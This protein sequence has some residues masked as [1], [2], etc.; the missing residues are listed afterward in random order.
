MNNTE[1]IFDN[2]I[3][4]PLE[5]LGQSESSAEDMQQTEGGAPEEVNNEG[6]TSQPQEPEIDYKT[7]YERIKKSYDHLRPKFTKVT[8]ELSALRKQAIMPDNMQQ[9]IPVDNQTYTD[10]QNQQDNVNPIEQVIEAMRGTV[11]EMIAPIQEQQQNIALQNEI[12]KLSATRE[13]FHEVA[14]HMY[15]VLEQNPEFWNFGI[16]KALNI[17]YNLARANIIDQQLQQVVG[18]AKQDAYR[19]KE[20]KILTGSKGQRPANHQQQLSPEQQILKSILG[21]GSGSSIF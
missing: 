18:Q 10:P 6:Q 7:E 11:A 19:N 17:S 15:E 9:D 2:T 1:N 4:T 14:P 21:E 3:E 16:E 8:Q 5:N 13:D 20:T 12:A